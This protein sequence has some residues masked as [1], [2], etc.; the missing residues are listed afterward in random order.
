MGRAYGKDAGIHGEVSYGV[1]MGEKKINVNLDLM[2]SLFF[3]FFFLLL[4]CLAWGLWDR[5]LD[6]EWNHE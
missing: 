1:L 4:L 2:F 3:S 5:G 6:I